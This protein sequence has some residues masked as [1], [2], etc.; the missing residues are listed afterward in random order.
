MYIKLGYKL[1]E[2]LTSFGAREIGEETC[3]KI[4]QVGIREG[5]FKIPSHVEILYN[6]NEFDYILGARYDY[7]VEAVA[8]VQ[9]SALNFHQIVRAIDIPGFDT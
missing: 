8:L 1:N 3:K 9:T 6:Y 2:M 4:M 7:L 5:V